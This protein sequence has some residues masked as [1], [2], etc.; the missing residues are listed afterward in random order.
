MKG[1]KASEGRTTPIISLR[2]FSI[3]LAGSILFGPVAAFAFLKDQQQKARELDNR[4]YDPEDSS[5]RSTRSWLSTP[6][7]SNQSGAQVAPWSPFVVSSHPFENTW[8]T[9]MEFDQGVSNR[10]QVSQIW[11]SIV[12]DHFLQDKQDKRFIDF[13]QKV[14]SFSVLSLPTSGDHSANP[15]VFYLSQ[16][17]LEKAGSHGFYHFHYGL[18]LKQLLKLRVFR[19]W[20]KQIPAN[21]VLK[22]SCWEL[23]L[24]LVETEKLTVSSTNFTPEDNLRIATWKLEKILSDTQKRFEEYLKQAVKM[25][26]QVDPLKRLLETIA[27]RTADSFVEH[28]RL[29]LLSQSEEGTAQELKEIGLQQSEWL[30]QLGFEATSVEGFWVHPDRSERIWLFPGNWEAFKSNP[31]TF[32]WKAVDLKFREILAIPHPAMTHEKK[33]TLCLMGMKNYFEDLTFKP[34]HGNLRDRFFTRLEQIL[35]LYWWS[36]SKYQWSEETGQLLFPE[37]FTL[38]QHQENLILNALVSNMPTQSDHLKSRHK[39]S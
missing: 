15:N 29:N 2:F 36:R 27:S 32:E 11:S 3:T 38:A 16:E 23:I 12:N 28:T 8:N 4:S 33:A 39:M 9:P 21:L 18:K 19:D 25:E 20:A 7:F 30:M 37:L 34:L 5:V 22:S 35:E 24:G 6:L 13:W 1:T 10:D 31:C 26:W 17:A 14:G